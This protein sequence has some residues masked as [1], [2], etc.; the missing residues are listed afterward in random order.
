M[1]A[2]I[3]ISLVRISPFFQKRVWKW[4]YQRLGKRAQ[5]SGWTFMNYGY[6]NNANKNL[7]LDSKDEKDRMFIQLY[8]YVAS[9][10]SIESL[11]I[12]EIGSGRGGGASFVA[13]YYK[14]MSMTGLDYSASAITLSKKLH[15]NV[16][17]LSFIR[18]D[19]ENLPFENESFDVVINVESSHCY[20]NMQ[21]FV[22]E[23]HRVIRPGGYFSW[24]DLRAKDMVQDTEKIFK[25]SLFK[26][27]STS[28][29]TSDVL[30]ALDEIHEAKIEMIE[31]HVPKALRNAFL[32]FAGAKGS[33]IYNAFKKRD[34]VYLSKV[35]QK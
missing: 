20:G 25:S 23:V 13:R 27:K 18:G 1:L 24:A 34:A 29:I 12:L 6:K 5:D 16:S 32:D 14:P 15:K 28:D 22:N 8:N 7:D 21:R 9:Q 10:V 11:K 33:K 3:F 30:R 2:K 4:W 19:A 31:R 17:N 35:F 26:C